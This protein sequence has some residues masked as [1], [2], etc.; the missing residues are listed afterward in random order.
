MFGIRLVSRGVILG[1]WNS[2]GSTKGRTFVSGMEQTGLELR[3]NI[4]V[5][6]CRYQGRVFCDGF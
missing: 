5:W 6:G 3:I 1:M 4:V 2:F